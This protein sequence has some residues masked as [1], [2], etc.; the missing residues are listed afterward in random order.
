MFSRLAKLSFGLRLALIAAIAEMALI[1][2][3]V[4]AGLRVMETRL[5]DQ[6]RVRGAEYGEVL[7]AS[8]AGSLMRKDWGV[9][10]DDI[11]ALHDRPDIEYVL[12]VGLDGREL[13]AEGR[14]PER[15][16]E[17]LDIKTEVGFPGQPYGH[18]Y[19]GMST[20]SV[21][22][23][24]AEFTASALAGGGIVVVLSALAFLVMGIVL[25]RGLNAVIGGAEAMAAGRFDV[26]L[27]KPVGTEMER[28]SG[29][30]TD[31]ARALERDIRN[32]ERTAQAL[33]IAA[34]AFETND[35]IIV[36]DA[37]ARILRVNRAFTKVTGYSAE[38]A[39]GQTPRILKSGRHDDEFFR[40]MWET[41]NRTGVWQ[42]EIWN[43]RKN[44]ELYPE[45]LTIS[46]VTDVNGRVTHYVGVFADISERKEAEEEIQR[47]A[48]YD[49]LTEL[50]NRRLLMDRLRRSIAAAKRR[51][52]HGALLFIDLDNFKTLND[53]FGHDFGDEL[54]VAVAGRLAKCVRAEDTVARLG[55]DEFVIM[56]EDLGG[57]DRDA[58]TQARVV[59]EKIIRAFTQPFPL[60]GDEYYS[61]TS[62]GVCLYPDLGETPEELL[63]RADTAMYRAKSG[64]RNTLRFFDPAMQE[65]LEARAALEAELRQALSREQF[66]LYYQAQVNDAQEIRGVEALL[67][68]RHPQRGLVAPGAFIP[69]AEETG[70][71]VPIGQWVLETACAQLKTWER[72]PATRRLHL[73]VNVSARQ[74]RQTDFVA[75]VRSAVERHAID[76]ALLKLELTESLVLDDLADTI[77]KMNVLKGAGIGFSLDDFGTGYS[78]LSHLKRLPL[79]QLKIDQSFIRDIEADPNDSII[80]QTIIA[81]AGHL[82]LDVIAEGVETESQL[83]F[84]RRHG[85]RTF[86]GFLFSTPLPLEEFERS[87]PLSP[88]GAAVP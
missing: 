9:L 8:L 46:A 4:L 59:G 56:L 53:T 73:A 66:R 12:L 81:M 18:L 71:I 22:Q 74:F 77:D 21:R 16:G 60:R 79:D 64:G 82:G 7:N 75:Q 25:T 39:V 15:P 34:I 48:F 83:D 51:R 55:G 70:L 32:R 43:R 23:A 72:S 63:R 87:L 27:P 10:A 3:L 1:A 85:C 69:V 28:L 11:K 41:L 36:T 86:Q 57:D 2:I 88:P 13:A 68:W 30:F 44:G 62:I 50:P 35:G 19:F 76:P 5:I 6:L 14:R 84:L 65:A 78:S 17:Y 47:L 20:G 67:R 49:P 38:E 29:A 40:N 61:T 45:W 58:A 33:R 80:V 31:M 37:D 26:T 52:G 42:G 24:M 54:L